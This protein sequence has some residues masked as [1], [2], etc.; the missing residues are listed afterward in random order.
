MDRLATLWTYLADHPLDA[1]LYVLGAIGAWV[2]LSWL[3][4]WLD[5]RAL[6]KAGRW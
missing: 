1:W 3:V 6:K 5:I 2:G 4:M